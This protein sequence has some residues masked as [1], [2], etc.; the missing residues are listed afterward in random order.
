MLHLYFEN[1]FLWSILNGKVIV[2]SEAENVITNIEAETF[3][4]LWMFSAPPPFTEALYGTLT[5]SREHL[6]LTQNWISQWFY[7]L[8][9]N[10]HLLCAI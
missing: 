8:E 5:W 4:I 10:I 7:Y 6:W 9:K 2:N 3:E 1:L